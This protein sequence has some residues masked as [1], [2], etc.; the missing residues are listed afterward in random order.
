MIKKFFRLMESNEGTEAEGQRPNPAEVNAAGNRSQLS[1]R[2]QIADRL[3]GARSADLEDTDGRNI[4]GRF[5]DGELDDSPE[6]REAAALREDEEARAALEEEAER[7]RAAELQEEGTEEVADPGETRAAARG[8]GDDAPE[9]KVIDGVKHYL[10]VTNG[11]EKWL[12]FPQLRALA[13]KSDAVDDALQR[14]NE[15]VR[16]ATQLDL[17]QREEPSEE[18]SDEQLEGVVSSAVMGDREAIKKLTTLI[19][20]RPSKTPDVSAEVARAIA[21]RSAVAD[22]ERQV[23]DVLSVDALGPVFRARLQAVAKLEPELSIA[24]AYKKAAD[25]VRKDFGPMLKTKPGSLEDKAQRKRT[26]VTPPTAASRVVR[27]SDTAEGEENPTSV[28]DEIA[29]SRGQNRA[30]RHGRNLSQG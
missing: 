16:S 23:S 20:P 11:K 30:I 4:T 3:D 5:A 21:T 29:K 22:A 27:R 9:E 19:K 28:I 12:T 2:Q 17:R 14:A 18:L 6:A 1:R 15:A 26:L 24:A 10:V 13:Q 25:Q 8:A 7:A